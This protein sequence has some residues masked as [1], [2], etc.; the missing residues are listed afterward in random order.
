MAGLF[1]SVTSWQSADADVVKAIEQAIRSA[2]D[3]RLNRI[4]PLRF[5][6]EHELDL[7]KTIA[8]FLHATQ[9]GIFELSW[10]VVCSTCGG[11]LHAAGSLTNID[12][13]NYTCALCASDCETRLDE[14][15]EVTFTVDPRVRTIQAHEPDTLPLWQ[16][17]RQCFWSSGSDLPDDVEPFVSEAVL[18]AFEVGPGASVECRIRLDGGTAVLFDPVTHHARFLEIDGPASAGPQRIAIAIEDINWP[19]DR[20]RIAPGALNLSI[21]NRT[22]QRVLP[23]LWTVGPALKRIVSGRLPVLTASQLMSSQAFRDLYG[24]SVLDVNQ[25]FKITKLSFLFVDLK[26]STQLYGRVGDLA[27]YDFVRAYFRVVGQIVESEG[28]AVVKTIGDAVMATFPIP[29]QAVR[30]AVAM[31]KALRELSVARGDREQSA[32]IGIHCGPCLAVMMND[33]Q[34]Y[35]GQTVNMASRLQG[36]ASDRILA[37]EAVIEGDDVRAYIDECGL[38]TQGFTEKLRGIDAEQAVFAIRS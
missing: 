23:I 25:H 5:A 6:A 18:N 9:R 11:V 8:G 29:L 19:T 30:S 4:N 12:C 10:N 38:A 27:A 17:A 22:Q 20:I 26:E 36:I 37:T 32:R 21:A 3:I 15:V 1:D 33:R 34:D 14:T 24:S 35:F 31:K 28:G 13:G 7:A 16:Y 2:P